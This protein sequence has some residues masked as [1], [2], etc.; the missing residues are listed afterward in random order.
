M[1][2]IRLIAV[3]KLKQ[4]FFRDAAAHYADAVSRQYKL[5]E[6]TVKDG[7]SKLGPEDKSAWEGEKILAALDDRDIP[8]CMDERGKARGSEDFAA[9]LGGMLEDQNRR[10]CFIVGGAF[11]FSPAVR[12]AGV[13]TISLG[14]MTLP[15]E[16][17]RVVLLEQ[18]YRAS[19]IIAG[20]P[21]HH[22]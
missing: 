5:E 17:A 12:R 18:L 3:G 13:H 20:I 9:W 2:T 21:Y 22:R 16:L 7:P 19:T 1:R 8:I 4:P 15:H 11:G 10:P 14:P 6:T